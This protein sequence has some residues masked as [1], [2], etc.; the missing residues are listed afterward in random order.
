MW[1]VQ[2]SFRPTGVGWA[3]ARLTDG[4]DTVT[5][6]A[7]DLSDALG[8]LLLAL[9]ELLEGSVSAMASWEEEPGEYRWLFKRD[10]ARASL[11]VLAFSDGWPRRPDEEGTVV[12]ATTGELSDLALAFTQG[13]RE[14]LEEH[15]DD[16]R[17]KWYAHPF[18][19]D[20]L[21]LVETAISQA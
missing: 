12:F 10:G 13:I 3:Q 15:G 17:E 19:T 9:A 20:F 16:Y 6:P 14:V 18:P 5:L 7:S 1:G 2:F 4:S 8:E 11:K 21:E